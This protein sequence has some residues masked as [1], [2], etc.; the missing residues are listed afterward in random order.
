MTSPGPGDDVRVTPPAVLYLP[1]HGLDVSA[2]EELLRDRG[3]TVLHVEQEPAAADLRAVVALLAGYDEVRAPL[4]D[5]LPALRLV[6]THSAGHEM[7]DAEEVARRGLWLAN[8]PDGATGEVAS[9]ALAM[10]LALVRRLPHYDRVVRSGGWD[11]Q[12]PPLPR[13][14]A[15]LTCAVLGLGRIG[16]AFAAMAGGLFARVVGHDPALP[17]AAWPPGVERYDELDAVLGVADCVSLHLPLTGDTRH[18]LDSRRLGLLPAGAVVV[19]VSRGGLVDTDALVA[20]LRSGHLGG[21]ACD[22]LPTEPPLPT[23]PV[24]ACEELLLSPHVGYL[25]AAAL[26]RYAET[27]ALNVLS[28]LDTGRPLTPVVTP[29][30]AGGSTA[31]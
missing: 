3:V 2:G 11:D 10:A 23:D 24:L 15:E 17:P 9:H 19:N 12:A 16:R 31:P 5:R 8:L 30:A 28:L 4:L 13:V 22:V 1:M 18:L 6:A 14:P 25:S 20:A 7:V 21:A 27:P 29:P 26:R